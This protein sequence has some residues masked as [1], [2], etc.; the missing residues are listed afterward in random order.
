MEKILKKSLYLD[1]KRVPIKTIP[2]Y[3][4]WVVVKNYNEFEEYILN[5]C[6]PDYISFAH[7]LHNEHV[8]DFV[9]YQAQGI[10]AINYGDFKEKTGLDCLK[11]LCEHIQNNHEKGDKSLKLNLVGVHSHNPMGAQNILHMAN[12]F[13]E[14]MG[15]TAD[16]FIAKPEFDIPGKDRPPDLV[17]IETPKIIV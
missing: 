15:W 9:N 12:S 14:H 8:Q 6:I 4:D 17:E 5:N 7:D 13:K 2:K 10:M 11:W 16:A 3:E 1:D